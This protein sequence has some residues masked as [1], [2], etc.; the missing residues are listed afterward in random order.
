MRPL[1][2]IEKYLGYKSAIDEYNEL[3]RNNNII[4]ISFIIE[5]SITDS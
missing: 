3:I 1:N 4:K 5:F 2:Q